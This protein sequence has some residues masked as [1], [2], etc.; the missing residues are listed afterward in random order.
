MEGGPP[1]DRY[2]M[3]PDGEMKPLSDWTD[4]DR[5]AQKREDLIRDWNATDAAAR[6]AYDYGV[7]PRL[8]EGSG[9][10]GKVLKK[11]VENYLA[12]LRERLNEEA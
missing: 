5:E 10:N 4:E 1:H 9:K 7:T 11:D 3:T 6:L 8:I 12:R 2:R